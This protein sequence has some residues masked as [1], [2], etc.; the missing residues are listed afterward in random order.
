VRGS[1]SKKHP[2]LPSVALAAMILRYEPPY[3]LAI[4]ADSK[5]QSEGLSWMMQSESIQMYL[6]PISRHISIAS[7]K[8]LPN[9]SVGIPCC[10]DS[11]LLCSSLNGITLHQQWLSVAYCDLSP[12]SAV[13]HSLRHCSSIS[14]KRVGITCSANA[15]F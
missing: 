7:R 3:M 10:K 8:V 1:R 13:R 4:R 11:R 2:I 14:I 15:H 9:L 5:A 12:R 6:T